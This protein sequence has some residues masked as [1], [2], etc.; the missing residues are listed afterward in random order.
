MGRTA[1]VKLPAGSRDFSLVHRVQTGSEADPAS[2]SVGT[3]GVKRPRL[4]ADYS[5]TS[6]AEVENVGAIHA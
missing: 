4:E 6:T 3:V 5:P 2:Y 1:G